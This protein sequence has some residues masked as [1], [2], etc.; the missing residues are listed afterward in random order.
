M[1]LEKFQESN[2]IHFK[3][4]AEASIDI[5]SAPD[6]EAALDEDAFPLKCSDQSYRWFFK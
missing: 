1:N 4:I 2:K 6:L 5:A 3:A